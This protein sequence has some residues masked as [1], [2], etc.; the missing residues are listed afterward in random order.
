M[1]NDSGEFSGQVGLPSKSGVSGNVMMVVPEKR[2]AVVTFSPRLDAAGNSVRGRE[3]CRRLVQDFGLHPYGQ[4]G[5]ER[6]AQRDATAEA[7]RHA[8]GGVAKAGSA[9]GAKT[10]GSRAAATTVSPAASQRSTG[11]EL[12]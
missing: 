7:A 6:G 5:G 10:T 1:Y 8:F 12:R 11:P 9:G 2:L 4:L 3:V